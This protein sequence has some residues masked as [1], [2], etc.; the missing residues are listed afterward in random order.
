[1]SPGRTVVAEPLADL[2]EHPVAA[3][4]AEAVVD[5][6]EVVE[7]D[8]QDDDAAVLPAAPLRRARRGR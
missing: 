5:R 7:V 2:L 6:L 3:L 4:V 1:M 8:E